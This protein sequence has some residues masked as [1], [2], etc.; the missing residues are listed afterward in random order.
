MTIA[1]I[2]LLI[3]IILF[4]IL[5]ILYKRTNEYKNRIDNI[6]KFIEGVPNELEIINIGSSYSKYAYDYS[7][8]S[9]NG[10]NLAIQPESLSYDFKILK[11]YSKN[12]KEGCIVLINIP[13]L[14]FSFTK[15]YS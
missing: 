7:E 14:V 13:N 15:R 1:L 11:Q 6:K 3:L 5:N 12:L 10:F 9:I 4:I 8:F 2:I